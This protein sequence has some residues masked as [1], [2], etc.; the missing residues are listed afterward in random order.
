MGDTRSQRAKRS[1][2]VLLDSNV[3]RVRELEMCLLLEEKKASERNL[4]ALSS[5]TP[6][7]WAPVR[8][9][10]MICELELTKELF[11]PVGLFPE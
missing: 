5:A 4:L 2:R 9:A 7:C 11:L 3:K 1:G 8:A 10:Q 6:L